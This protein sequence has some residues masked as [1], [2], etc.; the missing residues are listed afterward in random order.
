MVIVSFGRQAKGALSHDVAAMIGQWRTQNFG[1]PE[2]VV[3]ISTET[4]FFHTTCF[5]S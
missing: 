3:S 4:E 1:R 2:V 5:V